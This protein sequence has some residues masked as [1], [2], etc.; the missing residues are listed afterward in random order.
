MDNVLGRFKGVAQ[1]MGRKKWA[2]ATANAQRATFFIS[3]QS[4]E[5]TLIV[6]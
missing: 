2:P 3:I 6:L 5:L 4:I 1:K